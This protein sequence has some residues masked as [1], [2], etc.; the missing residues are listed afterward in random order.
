MYYTIN[1]IATTLTIVTPLLASPTTTLHQ[2]SHIT[3]PSTTSQTRSHYN[4]SPPT[5]SDTTDTIISTT[6][7]GTTPIYDTSTAD[8]QSD[9]RASGCVH[10]EAYHQSATTAGVG[11][12]YYHT[13][14]SAT[15]TGTEEL[16]G[17]NVTRA[18]FRDGG[19]EGTMIILTDTE[20]NTD[21]VFTLESL[22][23]ASIIFVMG[24]AIIISNVLII[25]TFLNF[26]GK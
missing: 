7:A 9:T 19:G 8:T 20:S 4:Q 11:V 14:T 21:I 10:Q 5:I 22:T 24:L 13:T 1:K 17:K 18:M 23:Q 25:A 12:Y 2:Y 26:R 16:L 15:S 3:T 6:S